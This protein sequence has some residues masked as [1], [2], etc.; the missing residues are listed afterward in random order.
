MAEMY[1]V[2]KPGGRLLLVDGCR[3]GFWGWFIYDV[4]VTAVEG[5]VRHVSARE[6][7]DLFDRAGFSETAQTVHHG[8]A[9]FLLSEGVVRPVKTS[10][11][12]RFVAP[13]LVGMVAT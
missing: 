8:P 6:V 4:C 11:S 3:D 10:D 5:N 2:L 12:P 1:R 13:A 7:R 9:P